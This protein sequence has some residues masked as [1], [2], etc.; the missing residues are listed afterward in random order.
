MRAGLR[1][2]GH[3]CFPEEEAALSAL[4]RTP[5][6]EGIDVSR[7][8]AN[9]VQDPGDLRQSCCKR[10]SPGRGRER[11]IPLTVARLCQLRRF[12]SDRH[13]QRALETERDSLAGSEPLGDKVRER[14]NVASR[15]LPRVGFGGQTRPTEP[16]LPDRPY[17]GAT[18]RDLVGAR[19]AGF[20]VEIVLSRLVDDAYLTVPRGFGVREEPVALTA[21]QRG[22]GSSSSAAESV[23]A[24]VRQE[25]IGSVTAW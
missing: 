25:A 22:C 5:A 15:R 16:S 21:V 8:L 2:S 6:Q 4:E 7:R 13:P 18:D 9:P 1:F 23:S 11:A 19:E 20:R 3:Q 12:V 24:A 10:R 14:P 17:V